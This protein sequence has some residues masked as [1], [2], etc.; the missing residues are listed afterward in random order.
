MIAARLHLWLA[1]LLLF[2]GWTGA[3][4]LL[5][6]RS[7]RPAPAAVLAPGKIM[8]E[9]PA[10]PRP[11]GGGMLLERG[12]IPAGVQAKIQKARPD[13]EA[14]RAAE[15]VAAPNLTGPVHLTF[16]EWQEKDGTRR[17]SATSEDSTIQGGM[18]WSFPEPPPRPA[19]ERRWMVQGLGFVD[20]S[21]RMAAGAMV[22]H[23]RGPWVMSAGTV[24]GSNRQVFVGVGLHF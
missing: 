5:G 13:A 23:T 3:A 4:F 14:I 24:F 6:R 7:L 21:G 19:V 20:T 15:V 2:A 11:V 1:G 9:A 10:A 8:V 18:D 22:S 16:T 17:I 12:V